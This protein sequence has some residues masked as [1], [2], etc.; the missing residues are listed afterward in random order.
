MYPYIQQFFKDSRGHEFEREQCEGA[1]GRDWRKAK[2]KNNFPLKILKKENYMW[3]GGCVQ[4][5]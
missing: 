4:P 1:C 5:V 2:G 3:T